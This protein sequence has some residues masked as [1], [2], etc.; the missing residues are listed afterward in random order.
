M[1]SVSSNKEM[2]RATFLLPAD[3]AYQSREQE[4]EPE[5]PRGDDPTATG[6]GA[7]VEEGGERDEA[8]ETAA[9]RL[10]RS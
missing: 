10:K 5:V 6:A 2:F 1:R 7:T 3:Y 4:T 9:K 8:G